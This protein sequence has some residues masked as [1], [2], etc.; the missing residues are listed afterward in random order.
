MIKFGKGKGVAQLIKGVFSY[1]MSVKQNSA[2][3]NEDSLY[4]SLSKLIDLVITEANKLELLGND[5]IHRINGIMDM[6][7]HILFSKRLLKLPLSLIRNAFA[8]GNNV[9][10]PMLLPAQDLM[11]QDDAC[12]Q[13]ILQ[14]SLYLMKLH[15]NLWTKN[16]MNKLQAVGITNPTSLHVL[17]YGIRG[18]GINKDCDLDKVSVEVATNASDL[19]A[20][21]AE[22]STNFPDSVANVA[23]AATNLSDTVANLAEVSTSLLDPR[24]VHCTSATSI[25]GYQAFN[26]HPFTPTKM[27]TSPTGQQHPKWEVNCGGKSGNG[28]HNDTTNS[29]KASWL[30]EVLNDTDKSVKAVNDY[31][32]YQPTYGKSVSFARHKI[33]NVTSNGNDATEITADTSNNNNNTPSL[34]EYPRD[35]S[36]LSSNNNVVDPD[37]IETS[38]N[39]LTTPMVLVSTIE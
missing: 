7:G 14:C 27:Q 12:Q 19:V 38:K 23:E 24:L 33:N 16:F 32:T 20:N 1:A 18:V 13:M 2:V 22:E 17:N 11:E 5:D 9:M 6:N 39:E 10:V 3:A 15:P 37:A 21:L 26:N 36:A 25:C 34:G 8:S 35:G 28:N 31:P 4:A 29:N 30:K